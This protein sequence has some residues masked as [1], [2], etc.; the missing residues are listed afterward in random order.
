MLEALYF[1]EFYI[2]TRNEITN[3]W[4]FERYIQDCHLPLIANRIQYLFVKY[5]CNALD[6]IVEFKFCYN[7]CWVERFSQDFYFQDLLFST[8][9]NLPKLFYCKE[10]MKHSNFKYIVICCQMQMKI[11]NILT[12]T[13]QFNK[14]I[15]CQ[16]HFIR[17]P[18][19][20]QFFMTLTS[21][22]TLTFDLKS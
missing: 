3:P 8:L 22:V 10:N 14:V 11:R 20:F 17:F 12:L 7:T 4:K 6:N 2:S 19:L 9:S 1:R 18:T 15:C 5:T 21:L 13:N 16:T